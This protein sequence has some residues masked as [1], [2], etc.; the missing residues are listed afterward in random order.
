MADHQILTTPEVAEQLRVSVGMLKLW[1]HQ[2]RGP[3]YVKD[4]GYVRYRQSAIDAWLKSREQ[5][6][7]A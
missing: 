4:G 5:E 3:R 6:T 1:R 2:K 7:A